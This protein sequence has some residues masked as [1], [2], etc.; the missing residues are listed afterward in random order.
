MFEHGYFITRLG[1]QKVAA[2]VNDNIEIQNDSQG[3]VYLNVDADW[4]T[5]LM[6]GLTKA[7]L[8]VNHSTLYL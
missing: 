4:K 2:I 3:V 7:G 1:C 8:S 5:R 6:R